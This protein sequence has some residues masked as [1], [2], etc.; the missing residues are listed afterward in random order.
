MYYDVVLAN[1]DDDLEYF[2]KKL[3]FYR[4]IFKEE[5]SKFGIVEAKDYDTNRKLVESKKVL[6]LVNP[7]VNTAKDS[8]HFRSGG[9]DHVLCNLA[10]KNGVA[11][12]FSLDSLANSVMLGRFKQNIRLCRKYKVKMLFFSFAK[13]KYEL[14]AVQD[15]LSLLR[16]LGMTGNEAK[17]ALSGLN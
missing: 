9:L 3:G 8:L 5:F 16:V 14:R 2:A 4:L 15:I 11:I 1:K 13:S 6:V 17:E 7:H 12:G 10:N